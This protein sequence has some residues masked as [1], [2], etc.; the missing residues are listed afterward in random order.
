L[1]YLGAVQDV[2]ISTRV[3]LA[4]AFTLVSI[5]GL[6]ALLSSGDMHQAI[7]NE[8]G[9]IVKESPD[10][11]R[12]EELREKLVGQELPPRWMVTTIS[13]FFTLLMIAAIFL[14]R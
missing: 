13:L 4:I 3:A 14:I 6:Q 9:E 11:V 7:H 5:V 10:I 2:S 8:I 1:A 12:S